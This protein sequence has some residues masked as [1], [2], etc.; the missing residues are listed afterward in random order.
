MEKQVVIFLAGKVILIGC[1]T[2]AG[3]LSEDARRAIKQCHAVLFDRLVDEKI[4]CLCRGEKIFVGKAP[5]QSGK[6]EKINELL[7]KLARQG[8]TIGRLKAGDALLFSRGCEEKNFLEKH[9]VPVEV[10]SGQSAL[11]ALSGAGIPL[12]CRGVSSSV[13]ILTGITEGGLRPKSFK[14]LDSDTVVFFMPLHNVEN[15]VAALLK[16][17]PSRT[18]CVFVENAGRKA[19]RKIFCTLENAVLCAKEAGV[20][21]PSLFVVGNCVAL[22]APA[23]NARKI[24][25]FREKSAHPKIAG[26]FRQRGAISLNVPVF[27]I[28]QRKIASVPT[29]GGNVFAFTSPNAVKSVFSQFAPSDLN[30]IFVAIGS[31][32]AAELQKFGKKASVPK[33]ESVGGLEQLLSKL[34]RKV[35]K[36]K[37]AVFCSPRTRLAGFKKIYAYDAIYSCRKADILN[38]AGRADVVFFTSPEILRFVL[39][40]AG[41]KILEG[42]GVWIVGP[43]TA[44]EAKEKG[45]RVDACLPFPDLEQSFGGFFKN[46][47]G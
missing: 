26:F 21:S 29:G 8:K 33:V 4:L 16:K 24:L 14:G 27:S 45:L 10:I 46:N 39:A 36:E 12:T 44:R 17:K 28:K 15:I 13:S 38:A 11:N 2:S 9:G 19:E 7:L 18:P 22:S 5:G 37:I 30:G 23:L 42:K 1:G 31:V 40:R 3:Q 6:Q 43:S 35:G 34:A 47:A 25:S 20:S 41:K 32:T